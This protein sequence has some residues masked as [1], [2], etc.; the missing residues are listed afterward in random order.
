MDRRGYVHV[1]RV[2][3]AWADV[4]SPGGFAATVRAQLT[5][6]NHNG[7]STAA[8]PLRAGTERRNCGP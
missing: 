8:R 5:D 7:L 2:C 4:F 6:T 1:T 3:A